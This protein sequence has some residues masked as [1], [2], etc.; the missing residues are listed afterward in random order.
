M[1]AHITVHMQKS[2]SSS[3]QSQ[4]K[5]G[6]ETDLMGFV[7]ELPELLEGRMQSN[8]IEIEV[9]AMVDKGLDLLEIVSQVRA[10]KQ[11]AG[12]L[13]STEHRTCKNKHGYRALSSGL[14]ERGKMKKLGDRQ[15]VIKC[16]HL[17][18]VNS[19]E[20]EIRA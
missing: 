6:L 12:R 1:A 10:R 13:E 18:L 2:H 11:K 17:D 4:P 3:P 7:M 20:Q 5:H 15:S 9:T 16:S 14:G 19:Q 8:G